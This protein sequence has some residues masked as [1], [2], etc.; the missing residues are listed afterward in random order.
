LTL[1]LKVIGR[2][3]ARLA[4][5]YLCSFGFIS[6]FG[7]SYKEVVGG[8]T[9]VLSELGEPIHKVA[10]RAVLLWKE[11]DDTVFALPKKVTFFCLAALLT[12][13]TFAFTSGPAKDSFGQK[14]ICDIPIE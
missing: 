7:R 1:P 8:I 5:H 4:Y 9:T 14:R 2:S 11:L 13:S 12:C 10:T 6:F 3:T